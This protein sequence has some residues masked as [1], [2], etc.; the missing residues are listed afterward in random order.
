MSKELQHGSVGTTLTQAEWE[1]EGTH[2]V[3]NQATGDILYASSASQLKGLAKGAANTVL[4]MGANIPEWTASL[5]LSGTLTLGIN[6][7]GF[8]AKFF[9]DTA[10]K[11]LLWDSSQDD[12]IISGAVGINNT[13][14]DA[15]YA[16]ADDLVIGSTSAGNSGMTILTGTG[17][18]GAIYFADATDDSSAEYDGY[19]LYNHS[20]RDLRFGSGA[21]LRFEIAG[22][23]GLATFK[24]NVK[25][26]GNTESD[27]NIG[28]GG[29]AAHGT[30][31]GT[32]LISLFNGTAPAGTLTNGAS[33]FCAG[34]EMK[35]IDAAGNITVLSPHD[36]ENYWVFDSR[37]SVTGKVLHIHMEKLMRRLDEEFGGGFIEEFLEI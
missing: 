31:A 7:T 37:N 33:F 14:P 34:G 35:V 13:D 9:G 11:Y 1:G 5:A 8:D 12:L 4:V 16:A 23:D 22:A 17:V 25:I 3:D 19:I 21:T 6:D 18:S 15:S 29:N 10:G 30:T 28:V 24:N 32:N 36:D 27:G 20:A 26:D 2:T